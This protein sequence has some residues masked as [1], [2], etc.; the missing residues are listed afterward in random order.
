MLM[1]LA[2]VGY[3]EEEG[4]E[5]SVLDLLNLGHSVGD[6]THRGGAQRGVQLAQRAE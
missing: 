3:L 4:E 6:Q 5:T 1:T 2:A